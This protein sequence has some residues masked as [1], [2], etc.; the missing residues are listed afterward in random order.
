METTYRVLRIEE[1][2]YGCEEL[3]EGAEVCCDVVSR[4]CAMSR[5]PMPP[6]PGAPCPTRTKSSPALASTRAA[7]S[8]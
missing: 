1:Q 2:L 6:G 4:C 5:W 7:R 8:S 3:P